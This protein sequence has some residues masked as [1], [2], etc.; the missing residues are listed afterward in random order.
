MVSLIFMISEWEDREPRATKWLNM[1][2]TLKMFEAGTHSKR[3]VPITPK[4]D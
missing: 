3:D 2:A 1:K 4:I